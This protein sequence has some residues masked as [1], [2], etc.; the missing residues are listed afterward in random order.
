MST[1]G[2]RGTGRKR[3]RGGVAATAATVPVSSRSKGEQPQ[4]G[5]A[6]LSR[7]REYLV[8]LASASGVGGGTLAV[9]VSTSMGRGFL[10]AIRADGM[11]F[12]RLPWGVLYT[13][14]RLTSWEKGDMNEVV[15]TTATSYCPAAATYGCANEAADRDAYTTAETPAEVPALR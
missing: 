5:M 10:L 12:V 4:P 3:G 1:P 14:E 7:A 11:S 2:Y 13:A 8:Q 15:R 6:G 9:P